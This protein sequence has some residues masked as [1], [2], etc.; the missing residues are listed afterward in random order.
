MTP[1]LPLPIP[2]HHRAS[3]RWNPPRVAKGLDCVGTTAHN[4][5]NTPSDGRGSETQVHGLSDGDSITNLYEPRGKPCTAG[6]HVTIPTFF[7]SRVIQ[8]EKVPLVIPIIDIGRGKA[9]CSTKILSKSR[10]CQF[11]YVTLF[12]LHTRIMGHATRP[13]TDV[14]P[15]LGKVAATQKTSF[16]LYSCK[17]RQSDHD[18]PQLAPTRHLL[19]RRLPLHRP[20]YHPNDE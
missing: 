1:G 11:R 4:D 2:S 14:F 5:R 12:R 3:G 17:N 7:V 15:L 18:R 6:A 16:I 19:P 20:S 13:R 8:D 10:Y 9:C